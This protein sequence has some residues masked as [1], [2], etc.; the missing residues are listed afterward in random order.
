[1]QWASKQAI[2]EVKT[3]QVMQQATTEELKQKVAEMAQKVQEESSQMLL[4]AQL[5]K[6]EHNKLV[7]QLSQQTQR[8][9][10]GISQVA[11]EVQRAAQSSPE[12]TSKYEEQM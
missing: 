3:L 10:Q 6:V 12:I 7:E 5:T 2:Q 9:V 1:M 11:L 8:D 4:Q